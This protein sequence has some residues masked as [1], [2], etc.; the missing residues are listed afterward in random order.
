MAARA[1]AL[2]VYRPWS[3]S[4]QRYQ[5]FARI[6]GDPAVASHTLASA[7]T[8]RFPG[9]V[10][11]PETSRRRSIELAMRS[12]VSVSPSAPSR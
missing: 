3:P 5:A 10:A 9:A 4:A 12:T 2:M 1:E 8:D 11:A 7:I 6:T